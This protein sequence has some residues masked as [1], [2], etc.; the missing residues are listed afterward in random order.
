[1]KYNQPFDQPGNPNAPYVDGNPGTGTQGSIPPAASIEY[2]QREIVNT[3][4]DAGLT[5]TNADNT[6]LAQAIQ[7]GVL[8]YTHDTG[9]TNHIVCALLPVPT[10]YL[11]GMR[12]RV[13]IANAN[14]GAVDLN[15]NSLGAKPVVLPGGT[16]L[17][18]GELGVGMI[19]TFDYILSTTSWQLSSVTI[20]GSVGFRN[21][22]TFTTSGTFT[23]PAGC[24]RIHY[25]V[26][27]AGGG[28]GASAG[29]FGAPGGGGGGYVEGCAS[30]T[31]GV[32][33]TITVGTGGASG[34]TPSTSGGIGGASSVGALATANGGAGGSPCGPGTTNTGSAGGSAGGTATGQTGDFT[35]SGLGA[36]GTTSGNNNSS[37]GGTFGFA[38]MQ[39]D[40]P[41]YFAPDAGQGFG[42]GGSGASTG[43][44][45]PSNAGANGLVII[46]Y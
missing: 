21:I 2:P 11:D 16:A 34:A 17:I 33:I 22:K 6:Q 44:T 27:G 45:A 23:P 32:G 38:G 26:W 5:P 24:T 3:I 36:F 14:T 46:M 30:V 20:A 42:V 35:M 10:A 15:A 41:G 18:G 1:M 9:T 25:R 13:K 19:G 39:N 7:S 12:I 40:G 28:G 8:E 4:T 43:V 31:P 29:T 37:G